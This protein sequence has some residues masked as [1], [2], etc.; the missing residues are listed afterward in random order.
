MKTEPSQAF[1]LRREAATPRDAQ[2]LIGLLGP[3]QRYA[4][5]DA[6]KAWRAT[7]R[8]AFDNG[9]RMGAEVVILLLEEDGEPFSILSWR[10]ASDETAADTKAGGR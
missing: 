7:V 9:R 6:G 3:S 8:V 2:A 10:D 1:L 4:T 5:S